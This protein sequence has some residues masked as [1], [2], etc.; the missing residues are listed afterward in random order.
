M[1]YALMSDVHAN[2]AALKTALADAAEAG[3]GKLIM[4][5]VAEG[6]EFKVKDGSRYI[7]NVGSVGH[8]RNDFCSSY[9][10]YDT[11][12]K[13]VTV[14]RIPFDFKSYIDEILQRKLD[15]PSWLY[16]LLLFAKGK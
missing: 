7:V 5:G 10:I 15:L 6:V 9:A 3:C 1:K 4:L 12:E 11:E 13:R 14:R 16:Q 8:P 2:P